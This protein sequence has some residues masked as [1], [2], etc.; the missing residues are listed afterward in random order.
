MGK[1]AWPV[2]PF[3]LVCACS[4]PPSGEGRESATPSLREAPDEDSGA[5]RGGFISLHRAGEYLHPPLRDTLSRRDR[6]S[7]H[8]ATAPAYSAD[9]NSFGSPTLIG[10]PIGNVCVPDFF[11]SALN[12]S[13]AWRSEPLKVSSF[14]CSPASCLAMYSRWFA[15]GA[16]SGPIRDISR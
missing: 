7:R 16:W 15:L 6:D 8:H 3:F 1:K 14:G 5:T 11:A 9:A 10:S 13:T 4:L 12:F 2:A